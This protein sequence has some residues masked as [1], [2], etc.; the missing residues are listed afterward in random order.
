[1]LRLAAYRG[2]MRRRDFL[3]VLGGAAASTWPLTARA[4]PQAKPI[5]GYLGT[6]PA[7][8]HASRLDGLRAG[9]REFGFVENDSF[10]F[11]ARFADKPDQ[12]RSLASQLVKLR[13]NVIVSAGNAAS[14]AL[15]SETDEIPLLFSVADDPVRLGLVASF[16]RPGGNVTGI[17][18]IS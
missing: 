8:S 4:Q 11:E 14:L 1:M 9:L 16:N 5:V 17:S 12:L 3:G 2:D 10:V 15:K 13:P 7:S 6:A 18:L